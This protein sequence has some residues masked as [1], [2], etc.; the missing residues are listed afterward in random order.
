MRT[1]SSEKKRY[2]WDR[3]SWKTFGKYNCR[4][5]VFLHRWTP[6]CKWNVLTG[7]CYVTEVL[8]RLHKSRKV[9]NHRYAKSVHGNMTV[10]KQ[11]KLISFSYC[12]SK[13]HWGDKAMQ[14]KAWIWQTFKTI[15]VLLTLKSLR[16][17][18]LAI[19]IESCHC[20]TEEIM[21]L[22]LIWDCLM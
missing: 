9:H 11:R 14:F 16:K 17:E 2:A 15:K 22:W 8:R 5:G 12:H 6:F 1:F 21:I 7:L 13:P 20:V 4:G 18:N 10:I 3:C 19:V